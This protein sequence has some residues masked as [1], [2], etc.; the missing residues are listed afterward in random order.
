MKALILSGGSEIV[1]AAL[2]DEF[3]DT[4]IPF[5]VVALGC[6]S[7]FRKGADYIPFSELDWPPES[8][9]FAI[10]ALKRILE[11]WGDRKSVV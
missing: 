9:E 3:L 1:A 10:Q 11:D 2:A 5:S 4:G 8:S 7:L 6:N